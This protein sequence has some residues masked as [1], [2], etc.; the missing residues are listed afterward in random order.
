MKE[1]G[2]PF[3]TGRHS[4]HFSLHLYRV[5]LRRIFAY[6]MIFMVLTVVANA[7]I[8][9]GTLF[10]YLTE[11]KNSV[12]G[13]MTVR[14]ISAADFSGGLT[15][16][17]LAVPVLY[18]TL[19]S[20][21]FSRSK[22]DFIHSLPY[23]R[24]CVFFSF[25]TA[26]LTWIWGTVLVS[27][28]INLFLFA[29]CPVTT[30]TPDTLYMSILTFF[31]ATLLLG[32]MVVLAMSTAGN[33]GGAFI[34]ILI[35]MFSFRLSGAAVRLA[36]STVNPMVDMMHTSLRFLGWDH[37]LIFALIMGSIGFLPSNAVYANAGLLI[38]AFCV[39]LVALAL[40]L[41][42]FVIRRSESAGRAF[43]GRRVHGIY[44]AALALP[45]V[46]LAAAFGVSAVYASESRS[47]YILSTVIFVL[48]AAAVYFIFEIILSHGI[49]HMASALHCL[50][51]LFLCG[52]A[53]GGGI[54]LQRTVFL[55]RTVSADAVAGV[56]IYSGNENDIFLGGTY[57]ALCTSSVEVTSPV[58]ADF[59]AAAYA[60]SAEGVRDD[61]FYHR[62]VHKGEMTGYILYQ[63]IQVR[64]RMK[65]G[66]LLYR[67]LRLDDEKMQELD[68]I[69]SGSPA[70]REA[71]LRIPSE[72]ELIDV[73]ANFR[74]TMPV[75]RI[76]SEEYATLTDEQKYRVIENREGLWFSVSGELDLEPF[77]SFY[78][79]P[80]F[81]SRTMQ[82]YIDACNA[83]ASATHLGVDTAS[84]IFEA[85]DAIAAE[86]ADGGTPD[87]IL[88]FN[89]T[90]ESPYAVYDEDGDKI[91]IYQSIYYDASEP[92]DTEITRVMTHLKGKLSATRRA[93]DD[94]LF[95]VICY[96]EHDEEDKKNRSGDYA[97]F[98][99]Y[100]SFDDY[101]QLMD[102]PEIPTDGKPL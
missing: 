32:G 28:L 101:R 71:Y 18:Y 2:I 83:E 22:S 53:V 38:S 42:A 13:N 15:L 57:E 73:H 59:I 35:I 43:I 61:T 26:A 78:Y 44:R 11:R 49:R 7:V 27:S 45:L 82:A 31:I 20:F 5:A 55:S 96:V 80:P 98:Y 74:D 10:S 8:P 90:F 39:A 102:L 14:T 17:L 21:L 85:F 87:G 12:I 100:L 41:Y 68:R 30:L 75:W 6:G 94:V 24:Q 25:F 51:F 64:I 97:Y 86:F 63:H 50:P 92:F 99:A 23:T 16:L 46:M 52:V 60:D 84:D 37:S 79:I 93:E 36:I 76:F 65:D 40:A 70:Y 34:A 47:N 58:M 88:V 48:V 69:V 67:C 4:P 72:S 62:L 77:Y 33:T 56:T 91:G 54:C 81:M 3:L 89:A 19:F 95:S 9:L 1:K 66:S 29:V